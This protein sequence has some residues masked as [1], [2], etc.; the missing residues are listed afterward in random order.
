MKYFYYIFYT[1]LLYFFRIDAIFLCYNFC[2]NFYFCISLHYFYVLFFSRHIYRERERERERERNWDTE[3]KTKT[4]F[5][6]SYHRINT[7]ITLFLVNI[8]NRRKHKSNAS[9]YKN[10]F[11]KNCDKILLRNY[12]IVKTKKV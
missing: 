5:I 7:D 8:S 9:K 11:Y 10:N 6:H 12:S 1:F 3:T 2:G 4:C